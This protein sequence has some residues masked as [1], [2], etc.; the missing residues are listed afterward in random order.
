MIGGM[1]IRTRRQR[2]CF[3]FI[4]AAALATG[5]GRLQAQVFDDFAD[6]NDTA[7]PAWTHLSGYVNSTGQT[8][9]ASTGLYRMTA[10]NNGV[11][12]LGFVG[13]YA[14][15]TFSN[16]NV[17][18]EVVSFSGSPSGAVFG[19]A[20]RLN[21]LNGIGQLT[22]YAFAYEPF[23]SG[24]TGE[25]VLYRFN[26]GVT[27]VDLGSQQVTLDPNK[28]YKFVLDIQGTQLH[29]QVFE[30]G[31]G[32]VAEKFATDAAYASGFS[33][34]IAYS[35][36][37]LPPVD[38]TWDNFRAQEPE[39][40]PAIL[41]D[42]DGDFDIDVADYLN[43]STH[44]LTNVTALT[45][46]QAYLLGDFTGDLRINGDDF[47]RFRTAYDEANGVGAF[48][49]MVNALPEPS[50]GVLAGVACAMLIWRR[51]PVDRTG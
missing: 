6:L 13:S 26:P 27:I 31:G 2:G 18:A 1:D 20:V 28:D 3:L 19:A 21:G 46:Q 22:G 42:F 8:W 41:G 11:S 4:A 38:V 9:D 5:S 44:L 23:A 33:G 14:G 7:N 48:V 50:T 49:A 37:P 16:V 34:F 30:I 36:N 12:G 25:A 32:M 17:S 45:I 40:P 15:P 47:V 51:R 35:Q 10:V 43:L 29:G 39:L 24:G